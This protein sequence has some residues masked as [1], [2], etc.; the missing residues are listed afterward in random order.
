MAKSFSKYHK[1]DYHTLW[2]EVSIKCKLG[3]MKLS[4]ITYFY[5]IFIFQLLYLLHL[6]LYVYSGLQYAN[7]PC[8]AP[9]QKRCQIIEL[10]RVYN[11]FI[12]ENWHKKNATLAIQRRKLIVIYNYLRLSFSAITCIR[13]SVVGGIDGHTVEIVHLCGLAGE[14]YTY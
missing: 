4:N 5:V 8:S 9:S 14:S 13:F 6:V 11:L 3:V 7:K 10:K 1:A 12:R 2:H